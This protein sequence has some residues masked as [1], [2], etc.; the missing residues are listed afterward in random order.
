[1]QIIYRNVSNE[2]FKLTNTNISVIQQDTMY[3][4]ISFIQNIQ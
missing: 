4:I 1:M 3:L 2:V